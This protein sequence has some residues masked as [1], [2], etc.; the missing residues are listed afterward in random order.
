MRFLLV[1]AFMVIVGLSPASM[2]QSGLAGDWMLSFNTPQ[3]A[4]DAAA[5]FKVDGTKLTGTLNSPQ[6]EV[7][8]S[9]TVKGKTFTFNFTAQTPNGDIPI[10]MNGE[11]DGDSIKGT[12]DYGQG[13]GDWTGKRK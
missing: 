8:F 6:G 13:M 5:T 12:F 1:V 9:G 10:T 11:Q 7:Q 4:I 3:G 2:A